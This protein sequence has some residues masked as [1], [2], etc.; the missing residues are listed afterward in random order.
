[1]K[2]II[3]VLS[4]SMFALNYSHAETKDL[5]NITKEDQENSNLRIQATKQV[6][7]GFGPG[8]SS[9]LNGEGG[10]FDITAGYHYSLDNNSAIVLSGEFYK[11]KSGDDSSLLNVSLGGVYHF[12][13][14]KHSPFV[15]LGFGYGTAEANDNDKIDLSD[16]NGWSGQITA[17]YKMFRLTNVNLAVMARYTTIFDKVD[18]VDVA[19]GEK[20]DK[21]PGLLSLNL[22]IY[23]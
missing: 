8:F 10:G 22:A 14:Q 19:T 20:S 13:N 23:Y 11:G 7:I 3:L 12:T 6:F 4:F 18:E 9:G 2:S 17:G 16:A 1:M 5:S 21:I 15:G